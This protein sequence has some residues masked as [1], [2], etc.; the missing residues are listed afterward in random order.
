MLPVR[1]GWLALAGRW[2]G[3]RI[4]S[5]HSTKTEEEGARPGRTTKYGVSALCSEFYGQHSPRVSVDEPARMDALPRSLHQ[6]GGCQCLVLLPRSVR[7][8]GPWGRHLL[9]RSHRLRF[10]SSEDA[11]Q[12]ALSLISPA[13]AAAAAV[14]PKCGCARVRRQPAFRA[15]CMGR[16]S[17]KLSVPCFATKR[18]AGAGFEVR[19]SPARLV[20]SLMIQH[21]C[22]FDV[23][24]VAPGAARQSS[25]VSLAPWPWGMQAQHATRHLARAA[26]AWRAA[27]VCRSLLWL[28]LTPRAASRR[29]QSSWQVPFSS[30]S[31]CRLCTTPA[32]FE[33]QQAS[34]QICDGTES[35][36]FIHRRIA[37]SST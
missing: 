9:L 3:M 23:Q 15:A 6:Q 25:T 4:L 18:M 24:G 8:R 29:G 13:A 10:S 37:T 22:H 33:P 5:R 12:P 11:S 26:G 30:L 19:F 2:W 7:H 16:P 31:F 35:P 17:R 27:S 28:L 14:L 34:P 1:W 21:I 36:I 20:P 32:L